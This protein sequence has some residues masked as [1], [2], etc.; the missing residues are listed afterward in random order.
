M[1]VNAWKNIDIE[2][3]VDVSLDDCINEMLDVATS[4]DGW[5]R[6]FSAIDGA[7]KILERVTPEDSEVDRCN[8]TS[9]NANDNQSIE[10]AEFIAREKC[11]AC[12]G[13]GF[14][15][16]GGST[17]WGSWITTACP[18]C[19]G[20]GIVHWCEACHGLGTPSG[21]AAGLVCGACNGTGIEGEEE[22]D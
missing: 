13:C 9:I 20:S 12:T 15:D 5:R 19:H 8:M 4:E 2:T 14:V 1:K 6:K 21:E 17:P 10:R 18:T 3:E 11:P 7:T 22:I 16:T